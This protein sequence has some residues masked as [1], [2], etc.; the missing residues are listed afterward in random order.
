MNYDEFMAEAK[1]L[2]LTIG[3][4]IP[5]VVAKLGEMGQQGIIRKHED[6]GHEYVEK[7]KS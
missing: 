5:G 6:G 7:D 3:D 2:N 1:R 4:L